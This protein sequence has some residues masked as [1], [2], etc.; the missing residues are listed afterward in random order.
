[1]NKP[2]LIIMV[3]NIGSGKTTFIKQFVQ[4]EAEKGINWFVVSKDDLRKMLGVG[5]YIWNPQ[6]EIIISDVV[7]SFVAH[8]LYQKRNVIIDGTNTTKEVRNKYLRITKNKSNIGYECKVEAII[9]PKISKKLSVLR[10]MA[11][12][13]DENTSEHWGEVWQKFENVY[14]EPT[15][16]EG[17]DKITKLS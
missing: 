4:A 8:L 9:L 3:G 16:E 13:H 1:M 15:I 5:K 17:F 14:E 12:P 2:K 6:I 7:V 10:R 11:N